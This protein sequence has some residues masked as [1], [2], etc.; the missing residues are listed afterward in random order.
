MESPLLKWTLPERKKEQTFDPTNRKIRI[1]RF[2]ENNYSTYPLWY[3]GSDNRDYLSFSVDQCALFLGVRFFGGRPDSHYECTQS[4]TVGLN[5]LVDDIRSYRK[6]DT[7]N[8]QSKEQSTSAFDVMFE[9]PILVQENEIVK[10]DATIRGRPSYFGR[11]GKST[12]EKR[13]IT[14]NFIEPDHE[15][16]RTCV[17]QGQFHEIILSV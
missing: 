13:G 9:P 11:R 1:S 14:V 7:Y 10:M 12:V 16:T 3:Y 15:S 6:T 17:S 8:Q 4:Y 5:V 2:S